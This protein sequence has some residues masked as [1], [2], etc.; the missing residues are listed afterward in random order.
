MD[1]RN[2]QMQ[3]MKN[4]PAKMEKIKESRVH[5][6]KRDKTDMRSVAKTITKQKPHTREGES[7][8]M[9]FE[10]IR[11]QTPRKRRYIFHI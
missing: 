1:I 10:F 8:T 3:F 4:L 5:R 9:D 2:W 11:E 7:V 6:I